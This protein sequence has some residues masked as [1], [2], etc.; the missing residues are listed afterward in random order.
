MSPHCSKRYEKNKQ[1]KKLSDH[2]LNTLLK[3]LDIELIGNKNTDLLI[4]Y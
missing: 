3:K 4:L 1:V 2:I